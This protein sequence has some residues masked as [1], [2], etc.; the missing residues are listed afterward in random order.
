MSKKNPKRQKE[1]IIKVL[2]LA[3]NN[4]TLPMKNFPKFKYLL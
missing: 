1:E 2:G 4:I 3:I